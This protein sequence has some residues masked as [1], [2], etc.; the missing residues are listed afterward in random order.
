MGHGAT[1][2]HHFPG[3]QLQYAPF[4]LGVHP[5]LPVQRWRQPAASVWG[6]PGTAPV[7]LWGDRRHQSRWDMCTRVTIE[8][9]TS[10]YVHTLQCTH[11]TTPHHH[12][13]IK[14]PTCTHNTTITHAC[15][16]RMQTSSSL[17]M[18]SCGFSLN[19]KIIC[20]SIVMLVMMHFSR[21]PMCVVFW[22][23]HKNLIINL[24]LTGLNETWFYSNKHNLYY[25]IFKTCF[26]LPGDFCFQ[27]LLR[28]DWVVVIQGFM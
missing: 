11:F 24:Y 15:H 9:H 20:L 3:A 18:W 23:Q 12:T 17:F 2:W 22:W 25:T 6:L 27:S 26:S 16:S 21:N 13:L 14:I 5:V 7:L 10:Q 19:S 28:F 4:Q 1:R 8:T